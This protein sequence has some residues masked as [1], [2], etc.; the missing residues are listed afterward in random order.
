MLE[1]VASKANENKD[2]RIKRL[3][4]DMADTMYKADGVGLA[5]PQIG[6]SVRIMSRR[7]WRWYEVDWQNNCKEG[8]CVNIEGCLSVL[9]LTVRS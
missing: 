6:V 4:S 9:I 5:T 7:C 3:L 8:S 2:K 1:Q